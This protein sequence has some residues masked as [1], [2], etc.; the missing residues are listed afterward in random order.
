MF[1][2]S[3][4][5]LP[6][7][8]MFDALWKRNS[9]GGGFCVCS[10]GMVHGSKGYMEFEEFYKA[11][12]ES[13][14]TEDTA[15]VHMRIAT[16][17]ARDKT[18]THP[19]PASGDR[20]QLQAT[21]WTSKYGV[22]H[23]G[24]ITGY[25]TRNEK[26]YSALSDTQEFILKNLSSPAFLELL[27]SKDTCAVNL[28]DKALG[29]D[30]MIVLRGDGFSVMFGFWHKFE[31]CEYSN[32]D[33]DIAN[34][35]YVPAKGTS[36]VPVNDGWVKDN[37]K[38]PA[39][40]KKG[41]RWEYFETVDNTLEKCSACGTFT[42]EGYCCGKTHVCIDCFLRGNESHPIIHAA[43]ESQ[44]RR[45]KEGNAS[46]SA[47]NVEGKEKDSREPDIISA[48]ELPASFKCDFV[49]NT[50]GLPTK[51]GVMVRRVGI[52][53]NKC[54]RDLED[55]N[56]AIA[57]GREKALGDANENPQDQVI[58]IA[59]R[60]AEDADAL[61]RTEKG[62][63]LTAKEF[64]NEGES[65]A[66]MIV[67]LEDLEGVPCPAAR[68]FITR[69]NCHYCKHYVKCN[70]C[71]LRRHES[72]SDEVVENYTIRLGRTLMQLGC[73]KLMAFPIEES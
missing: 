21:T 38:W 37:K 66:Q 32:M 43:R 34:H 73:R 70:S 19:F 22:A 64:F 47:K 39:K 44:R 55:E 35:K 8:E 46:S 20:G 41:K 40:Y 11:V 57:K 14:K 59:D 69:T 10:K 27:F 15:I 23:N 7:R 3:G 1:K 9:H 62:R 63:F 24:V 50:C 72:F 2:P 51:S 54:A 60:V 5:T 61:F 58:P 68:S 17:G 53:C 67:E 65:I 49:C 31:G 12:T 4:V 71:A 52:I 28:I 25:G 18:A 48:I 13:I 45:I 30:R 16:H 6:N 36:V 33:Y 56:V 26:E 42:Y 29:G